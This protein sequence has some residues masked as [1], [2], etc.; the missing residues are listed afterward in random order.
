M[1]PQVIHGRCDKSHMV[2]D[3]SLA[4]EAGCPP[5]E[6]MPQ[7]QHSSVV[8]ECCAAPAISHPSQLQCTHQSRHLARAP[9]GR[10]VTRTA[11]QS[12]PPMLTSHTPRGAQNQQPHPSVIRPSARGC[13][14]Q[15]YSGPRHLRRTNEF[16]H[17]RYPPCAAACRG[18]S[19]H[20]LG[21]PSGANAVDHPAVDPPKCHCH[22]ML[23]RLAVQPL[24]S[25][26]PQSRFAATS[27]AQVRRGP[28]L[29]HLMHAN[30]VQRWRH[31]QQPQGMQAAGF[32][33]PP[34]P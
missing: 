15:D 28:A 22:I 31:Q 25:P 19:L 18:S 14:T 20:M 33:R 17:C 9:A 32:F 5:S 13:A 10:V 27:Q 30:H 21:Q 26:A 24:V 7:M 1:S 6:P 12:E 23:L 4:R 34:V 11:N 8:R 16:Q 3:A 29:S 2:T